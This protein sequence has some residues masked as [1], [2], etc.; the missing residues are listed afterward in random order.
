[1]SINGDDAIELYENGNV[2]DTFRDINL[3]G[4]GEPWDYLDGWAKR[5]SS[6]GPDGV[7]FDI[8]AWSFSGIYNLE[9]DT[10]DTTLVPFVLG[11]FTP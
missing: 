7:V 3:D 5:A 2:I 1:M 8:A 6:T 4:S 11:G 9:G 10:N